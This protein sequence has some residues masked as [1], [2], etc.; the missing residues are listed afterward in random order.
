MP[1][2]PRRQHRRNSQHQPASEDE[3]EVVVDDADI[4]QDLRTGGDNVC[5][6]F[7]HTTS[8]SP[9]P[10]DI[11]RQAHELVRLALFTEQKRTVIRREDINKKSTRLPFSACLRS[12]SRVLFSPPVLGSATRPFNTVFNHAQK[13]LRKTFGMELVELR[14]RPEPDNPTAG[15]QADDAVL[16]TGIKKRG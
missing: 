12:I 11:S 14:S 4:D 7:T 6:H 3:A 9:L 16:A 13:I 2:Q 10:Q 5:C 8:C 15:T 1:S